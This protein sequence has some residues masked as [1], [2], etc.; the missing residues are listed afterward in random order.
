MKN[1]INISQII[2]DKN[3][4]DVKNV[5][6]V[7]GLESGMTYITDKN[8]GI[9]FPSHDYKLKED[10]DLEWDELHGWLFD[11]TCIIHEVIN[12]RNDLMYF[13]TEDNQ[14]IGMIDFFNYSKISEGK[15]K[16]VTI[17]YFEINPDFR[18]KGLGTYCLLQ[19]EKWCTENFE[20][21]YIDLDTSGLTLQDKFYQSCGYKLVWV[22]SFH[23]KKAF[24]NDL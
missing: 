8:T 13:L 11:W 12:C 14:I 4:V 10:Y 20:I 2:L 15:I 19:F 5:G 3:N 9:K 17:N 1:P 24:V 22:D 18:R 16:N 6:F 23:Y 21:E 7:R